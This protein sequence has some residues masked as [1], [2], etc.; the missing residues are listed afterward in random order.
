M[1]LATSLTCNKGVGVPAMQAQ[2]G[3]LNTKPS[4]DLRADHK[5]THVCQF[6]EPRQATVPN[7]RSCRDQDVYPTPHQMDR[8][9]SLDVAKP[10]T[11]SGT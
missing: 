8:S 4:F 6:E 10:L 3:F 1:Y 2:T 11:T 7:R 5:V 9:P